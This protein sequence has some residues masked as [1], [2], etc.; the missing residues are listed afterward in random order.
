[1]LFSDLSVVTTKD[2]SQKFLQSTIN[3]DPESEV[4]PC[5]MIDIFLLLSQAI[6]SLLL[7]YGKELHDPL[8]EL[9]IHDIAFKLGIIE[10]LFINL[11]RLHVSYG[12]K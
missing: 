12:T 1:M 8:L 9:L 6:P 4:D 5:I 11:I 2:L 3:I 10:R 7:S